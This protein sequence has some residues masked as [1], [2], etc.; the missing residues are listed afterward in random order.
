MSEGGQKNL[1]LDTG[2]PVKVFPSEDGQFSKLNLNRMR[3]VI[4]VADLF[5]VPFE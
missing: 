5:A 2:K 4:T 3:I 1:S